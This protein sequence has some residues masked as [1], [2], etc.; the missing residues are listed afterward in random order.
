MI[1]THILH[2]DGRVEAN[3]SIELACAPQPDATVWVDLFKPT[4][5]EIAL[6][7]AM[8]HFHPL[9]VEDVTH[10]QKRSKYE[11]YPNH[12]FVVTQALDRTTDD[13]LDTEPISIFLR[14]GLVVSV[15]AK[16]IAAV[17]RVFKTLA[18]FPERVGSDADSIVHALVDAVVDEYTNALYDL[19]KRVD[20]LTEQATQ[21]EQI[22]LVE[23]LVWVRR[24]L[25]MLR[26]MTLPQIELV[27]RVVESDGQPND[28]A[29]IYFRDVLDHLTTIQEQ[30]ALLL[31][32]CNGALQVHSNVVN[33]R[34]NQVM[35]YL[36]IVSTL[37]LP[38]TVVSGIFGMN[39]DVI[40]I[41]HHGYGFWMAV[42][43]M[44]ASAAVLLVL[45]RARRWF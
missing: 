36:A 10:G 31:D 35:K 23:D 19:E 2:H 30:T 17:E 26:R 42:A 33:E 21:P 18:T 45:F 11:R 34:L 3:A 8:F 9:A 14:P 22:G 7:T 5:E 38:W 43:I 27:K 41:S 40:P 25:L 28:L 32:V 15:R 6:L 13:L 4:H 37:A 1:R 29:R 44:I 20:A 39:F 24:D 12:T 16:E